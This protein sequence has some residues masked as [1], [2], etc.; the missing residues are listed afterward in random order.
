MSGLDK[1]FFNTILTGGDPVRDLLQWLEQGTAFRT[2]RDKNAWRGFVEVIKSQLGFDPEN[3]G[4]L[5]GAAKLAAREGP[6]RAVWDRYCEAP[7]R[8]PNIPKQ[9]W[10]CQQ[11]P[12]DLFSDVETHGGWPQWN[13]SREDDLRNALLETRSLP[14]HKACQHLKDL[15]ANHQDRRGLVWAELGEAPLVCA[16]DHLRILAEITEHSAAAGNIDDLVANYQVSGWRA[17]DAVLGALSQI[18]KRADLEAIQTAIQAIYLPWIE[19]NTQHLQQIVDQSG[20]PGGVAE[21]QKVVF[22][23]AGECIL[24]VDGLRFDVGR[25]LVHLLT[26]QGYAVEEQSKWSALPS[27]TA[28]G[29][30]AV[31]PV[32]HLITGQEANTDF[33]PCVTETGQSLKGGYHLRKLLDQEGWQVLEKSADGDP[34]GSAWCAFGD[35]DHEG[36]DRGWKLAKHIGSMLDDICVRVDGL[37]ATGWKS[38]RIVTD[39]GWLLMPGGLP[40]IGLPSSLSESTWGRCAAIKAGAHSDE[41][42]FPWFWNSNQYFALA[43]GIIVPDI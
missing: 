42:L 33:E 7:K 5:A 43:S 39:H 36:H 20:Y 13:E 6:W 29:K 37:L 28:T 27:V 11:S 15:D 4:D 34:S 32:R 10:R 40:K 14:H 19:S 22:K 25:R 30:A 8:Y 31:S 17:D 41:R 21:T 26:T 35:I 9:I 3:D 24:F 1:D 16:L 23:K 38:V 2:E 12:I 18:G